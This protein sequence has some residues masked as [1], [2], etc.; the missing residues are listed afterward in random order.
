MLAGLFGA[1]LHRFV[2]GAGPQ[3]SAAPATLASQGMAPQTAKSIGSIQ[4]SSASDNK[5]WQL[6]AKKKPA[7]TSSQLGCNC[8]GREVK[9]TIRIYSRNPM[10]STGRHV[11]FIRKLP[12]SISPGFRLLVKLLLLALPCLEIPKSSSKVS[13]PPRNLLFHL[14]L[15]PATPRPGLQCPHVR[16]SRKTHP[17]SLD[18]QTATHRVLC[19]RAIRQH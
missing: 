1:C 11:S 7:F 16:G 17:R 15:P 12:V 14:D 6:R 8:R 19:S 9:R 18:M 5:N 4:P 3:P 2:N 10:S 13:F